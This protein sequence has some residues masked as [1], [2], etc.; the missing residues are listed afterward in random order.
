MIFREDKA[1]LLVERPAKFGGEVPYT[2]YAELEEDFK[3]KKLHPS[4]LKNAVAEKLIK[5]L[6]PARKHFE[7]P[8]VKAMLHELE[9]LL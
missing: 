7:H 2:S 4:D 8:R 1:G 9:S 3:E 6:E 5:I